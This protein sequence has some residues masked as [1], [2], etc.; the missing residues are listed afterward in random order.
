MTID[1]AIMDY[2][3]SEENFPDKAFVFKEGGSG[4]WIYVIL[5]GRVKIKKQ[6]SKGLLTIEALGEGDFI[7]EIALFKEGKVSRFTSAIADGPV[8]V[9]TLD[10]EQLTRDWEKQ[11]PRIKKLI[12]SLM[13]N[14]EDAIQKMVSVVETSK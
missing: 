6:T 12:S 9:G 8:L 10:T 4:D 13:L 2:V 7:G 14:L 3:V 1:S 5:E 11:S